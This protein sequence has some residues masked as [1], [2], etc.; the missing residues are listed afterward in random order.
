MLSCHLFNL[1]SRHILISFNALSCFEFFDDF[2]LF[3]DDDT[4]SWKRHADKRSLIF[5]LRCFS[6]FFVFAI[7]NKFNIMVR[8]AFVLRA[9]LY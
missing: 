6:R 9:F 5:L 4:K 7:T 3:V 8:I 2:I 1:I